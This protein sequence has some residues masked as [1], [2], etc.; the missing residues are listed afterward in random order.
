MKILRNSSY[1]EL[2]Y[3]AERSESREATA[4]L[5]HRRVLHIRERENAELR[6]RLQSIAEETRK[7]QA[8]E[9]ESLKKE[10]EVLI[11]SC[12]HWRSIAQRGTQPELP[13]ET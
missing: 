13:S 5:V 3:R 1:L 6:M 2:M 8:G 12:D 7:E 11:D 10:I 9:I 4:T